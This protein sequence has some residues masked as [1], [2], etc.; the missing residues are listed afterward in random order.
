VGELHSNNNNLQ[1][2]TFHIPQ[3]SREAKAKA[4]SIRMHGSKQ[5]NKQKCIILTG[6]ANLEW[7]GNERCNYDYCDEGNY[8]HGEAEGLD[9]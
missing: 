7:T 1:I 3:V 2:F 6:P 5:S 8:E 4:I 9:W